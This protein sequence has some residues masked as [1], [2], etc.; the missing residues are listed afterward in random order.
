M[1]QRDS[2]PF[3]VTVQFQTEGTTAIQESFSFFLHCFVAIPS[4]KAKTKSFHVSEV[5]SL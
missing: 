1:T 3:L 2:E 4:S 5:P